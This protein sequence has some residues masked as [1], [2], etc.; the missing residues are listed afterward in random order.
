LNGFLNRGEN[1]QRLNEVQSK[2]IWIAILF[3]VASSLL[4]TSCCEECVEE[5]EEVAAPAEPAEEAVMEEAPEEK[6][7]EPEEKVE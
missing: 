2:L 3:I 6:P 1:M 4:L 7:E 5:V